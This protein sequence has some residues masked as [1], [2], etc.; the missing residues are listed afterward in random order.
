MDL[1]VTLL[2]GGIIGWLASMIM[3]TDAQQGAIAN[4]VIGIVGS[5]LGRY[6]FGDLLGLG[7]AYS[8]GSFNLMGVVWGVVGAAVLIAI[9]KALHVFGGPT[10]HN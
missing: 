7:G 5:F 10:V 8:A 9:L 6:L 3:R 1:I 4:I 2:V